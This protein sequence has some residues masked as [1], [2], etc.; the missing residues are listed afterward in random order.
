MV[1]KELMSKK[2]LKSYEKMEVEV[3]RLNKAFPIGYFV[4]VVKDDGSEETDCISSPFSIMSGNVVAW[5]D[6]N[7]CYLADRVK[8]IPF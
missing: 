2:Q 5:L 3:E 6:K 7:R 4:S 8:E 1:H